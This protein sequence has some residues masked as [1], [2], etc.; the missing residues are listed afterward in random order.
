MEGVGKILLGNFLPLARLRRGI[1]MPIF[2]RHAEFGKHQ[3]FI[4]FTK[5]IS[6]I[7]VS[8]KWRLGDVHQFILKRHS[9]KFLMCISKAYIFG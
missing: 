1:T 8:F 9:Q 5:C 4:F 7:C 3:D 6:D 2:Y